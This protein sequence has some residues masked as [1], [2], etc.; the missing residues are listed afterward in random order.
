MIKAKLL[1]MCVCPALAAPPTILAVS[2]PARHAVAHVLHRAAN[3]LDH[4]SPSAAAAPPPAALSCTPSLTAADGGLPVVGS[5]GGGSLGGLGGGLAG[6]GDTPGGQSG[7]ESGFADGYGG[8]GGGGFGIGVG[9]GGLPGPMSSGTLVAGGGS[10]SAPAGP[11]A[12]GVPVVPVT[13]PLHA[14]LPVS[15]PAGPTSTA[16]EPAAWLL[17]VAGFGV[18]GGVV[19][20]KRSSSPGR[21]DPLSVQSA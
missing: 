19:R 12:P 7:G 6:I 11:P 9:G 17:M 20:L 1:A 5:E 13:F 2:P 16:P 21:S 4:H 10:P 15:G 14:P 8:G 18:V 3:R